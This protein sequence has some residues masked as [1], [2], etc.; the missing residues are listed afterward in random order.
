MTWETVQ[1]FCGTTKTA[2]T[3]DNKH[4]LQKSNATPI[5]GKIGIK[6]VNP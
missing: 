6:S 1:P 4:I 3:R 2:V 5:D